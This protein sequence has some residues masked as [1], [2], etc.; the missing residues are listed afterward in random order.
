MGEL[1]VLS[2][3]SLFCLLPGIRPS[4]IFKVD[5]IVRMHVPRTTYVSQYRR[6]SALVVVSHV[7]P[8]YQAAR[9]I[10]P[11]LAF[12]VRR[13]TQPGVLFD[14]KLS[15]MNNNEATLLVLL[16]VQRKG[17]CRGK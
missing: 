11:F 17:E 12:A 8:P 6:V 2:P 9:A 4:S 16:D 1:P 7:S 3:P 14:Q 13:N 5:R 15:E 10:G